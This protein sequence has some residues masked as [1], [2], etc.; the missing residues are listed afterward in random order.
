MQGRDH[1]FDMGRDD[2]D[3]TDAQALVDKGFSSLPDDGLERPGDLG[4]LA[5]SKSTYHDGESDPD[6]A[7]LDNYGD[8]YLY[9]DGYST[10]NA[11]GDRPGSPDW[12]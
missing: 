2:T 10:R 11:W 5:D 12:E 8:D 7:S 3:H 6:S 9:R 4:L 1:D